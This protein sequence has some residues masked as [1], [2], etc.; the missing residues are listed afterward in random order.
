MNTDEHIYDFASKCGSWDWAGIGIMLVCAFF[1]SY[2]LLWI[3]GG[4]MRLTKK[5]PKGDEKPAKTEK[6]EKAD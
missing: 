3:V 4:I 2:I 5:N 6:A 1:G